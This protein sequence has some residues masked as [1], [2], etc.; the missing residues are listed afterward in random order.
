[1]KEYLPVIR[2]AHIFSGIS[3]EELKAM[4]YCLD[5]KIEDY[6]KDAYIFHT[7]DSVTSIGLVLTGT[8]LIVQDDIWGNRNIVS[9]AVPGD[10]IATAYACAPGSLL[11][12]SVV[13]ETDSRIMYL[14]VKRVLNVC[15]SACSHHNRLIRNLLG[16]LAG[17]NLKFS[18]KL[19][20]IA[21][22]TTRAKLMSYL[23]EMAQKAG[24]CE[25]DIPFSRQQLADYLSVERSGLCVE[26]GKMKKEGLIEYEKN[27]FVLNIENY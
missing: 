3:E 25:F 12:V 13:A 7:G 14:N 6:P 15:P 8:V 27:H 20:H 2:S 24:S 19:T 23:S 11:N 22:R 21:Q 5:T 1:M 4:L 18:D 10:T 9:E 26:L 16:E 17:K